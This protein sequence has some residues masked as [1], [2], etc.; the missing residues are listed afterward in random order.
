[1]DN[2]SS[3]AIHTAYHNYRMLHNVY[4]LLDDNDRRTLRCFDLSLIQYQVLSM[5]HP[6][7]GE[8]LTTLSN[9]LLCAKSTITRVVDALEHANLVQRSTDSEDRRAQRVVLTAAGA[10]LINKGRDAH[11]DVIQTRFDNALTAEEQRQFG[12]LLDKL[13]DSLVRDLYPDETPD[14]R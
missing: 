12:A 1:V 11:D 14:T 2:T 4:V 6:F 13:R 5:L 3:T 9:R 7:Q 8:R 10:T